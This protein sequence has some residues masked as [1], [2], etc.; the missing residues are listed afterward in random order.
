MKAELIL[1]TELVDAIADKVIEK[2]KPLILNN[3]KRE[4]DIIFDVR[5]LAEFLNVSSKWIY[6]RV[7]LN[8]IPYLKV[9]G[10]LRFKKRNIEKWLL[11]YNVPL[12]T[13]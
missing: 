1:P 3:G 13:V 8:E 10:L 4:E 5:G 11:T 6:K 7:Q 2:L 9:K 12:N